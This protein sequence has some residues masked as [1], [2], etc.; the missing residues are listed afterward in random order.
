[1][2]YETLIRLGVVVLSWAEKP[3]RIKDKGLFVELAG[4]SYFELS[5]P[6]NASDLSSAIAIAEKL[7]TGGDTTLKARD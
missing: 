5:Q 7:R 1:M 6:N 4:H 3:I 2:F